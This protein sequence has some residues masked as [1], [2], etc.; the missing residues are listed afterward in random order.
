MTLSAHIHVHAVVGAPLLAKATYMIAPQAVS[1]HKIPRCNLSTLLVASKAVLATKCYC[2]QVHCLKTS[3]QNTHRVANIPCSL[4]GVRE[5]ESKLPVKG[6]FSV[7][8]MPVDRGPGT[9]NI[10]CNCNVG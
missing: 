4:C 1:L 5:A 2:M 8:W 9:R 6:C 3:T 7:A 10:T